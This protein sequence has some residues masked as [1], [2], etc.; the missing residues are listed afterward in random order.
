MTLPIDYTKSPP[1]RRPITRGLLAMLRSVTG[2]PFDV[3][4][5]PAP[6]SGLQ[7]PSMPYGVVYPVPGGSFTGGLYAGVESDAVMVYQVTT[8]GG[9]YDQCDWLA[10]HVRLAILG[11]DSTDR[12]VND[13]VPVDSQANPVGLKVI[14]R[15]SESGPGDVGRP[16]EGTVGLYTEVERFHLYITPA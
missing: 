6:D 13:I 8:V 7:N 4:N 2:R 12:F 10:D 14:D 1:V 16:E 11:R 15:L 3:A 5:V 9:T